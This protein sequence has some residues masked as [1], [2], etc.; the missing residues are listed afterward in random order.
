[1]FKVISKLTIFIALITITIPS[2][3]FAGR[4]FSRGRRGSH[5]SRD[6]GS[7][8]AHS[9]STDSGSIFDIDIKPKRINFTQLNSVKLQTPLSTVDCNNSYYKP[10]WPHISNKAKKITY[11]LT[12]AQKYI[13]PKTPHHTWTRL[14]GCNDGRKQ[15]YKAYCID[16][17]NAHVQSYMKSFI[18][19]CEPVFKRE[20]VRQSLGSKPMPYWAM[21]K[22]EIQQKI[23]DRL[24]RIDNRNPIS[25]KNLRV[26]VWVL[27]LDPSNSIAQKGFDTIFSQLMGVSLA[28]ATRARLTGNMAGKYAKMSKKALYALAI[29]ELLG[30]NN[31]IENGKAILKLNYLGISYLYEKVLLPEIA[32]SQE[33]L[34]SAKCAW[35]L[36]KTHNK[37]DEQAVKVELANESR[38]I[39]IDFRLSY[40]TWKYFRIP[41]VKYALIKVLAAKVDNSQQV[42]KDSAQVIVSQIGVPLKRVCWLGGTAAGVNDEC[43]VQPFVSYLFETKPMK[44]YSRFE[45]LLAQQ[46]LSDA[47]AVGLAKQYKKVYKKARAHKCMMRNLNVASDYKGRGSYGKMY[48]SGFGVDY[49]IKCGKM[50]Q[51]G[52]IKRLGKQLN[53]FFDTVYGGQYTGSWKVI[54]NGWGRIIKKTRPVTLYYKSKI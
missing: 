49:E 17:T 30:K 19:T 36:R 20:Q 11:H 5:G 2:T 40:K 42:I 54:K 41:R 29:D 12:K 4:R 1:M 16:K 13:W 27:K 50:K 53:N 45:N 23:K 21:T 26:Y 34:K 43:S 22:K 15:V 18:R 32:A 46:I 37:F 39:C 33:K 44:K 24:W 47:G 10:Y 25:M 35:E 28:Q 6:R 3:V 9:S 31:K 38:R 8:R 51:N 14:Q 48:L 7:S 52:T